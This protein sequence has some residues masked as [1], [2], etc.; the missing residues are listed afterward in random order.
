[1][2]RYVS[3]GS[4]QVNSCVNNAT[5]TCYQIDGHK[6]S[7]SPNECWQNRITIDAPGNYT[8]TVPSGV[9]CMRA[10]A[11]GGGGKSKGQNP[12]CCGM[13]GA[14]GGYSERAFTVTGG[15]IVSVVVG[16]QEANTTITYSPGGV[17]LTGGGANGCTGGS[18][19]G[20]DW[21]STGGCAGF[22]RLYCGGGASHYCGA[23]VYTYFTNCC[24]Y[25]VGWSGVSSRQLDPPHDNAVCCTAMY[26]GGGSAG[27]WI[28]SRGGAGQSAWNNMDNYG[29][30]YGPVA[31][32]GGGIGYIDRCPLR[33]PICACICVGPACNHGGP[34][35]P[36]TSWPA[37]AGG[38]GGSKWQCSQF[39]ICQNY[40]GC[41][42]S[43]RYRSGPGGW[44]GKNNNEGRE[45]WW[46]W[47]FQHGSPWGSTIR[48]QSCY[49]LP[50]PDPKYY[51]W[52]DIHDMQGSGSAG[53]NINVENNDWGYCGWATANPYGAKP[54]RIAGE[55]AG[56]GGI[57]F[58][59]CDLCSFGMQCC[60]T[61]TQGGNA[62]ASLNWLLVCCLGTSGRYDCACRMYDS[63]F[64][65]VINCAG[66]LGG[67]GGIGNCHLG[68][69]AGKGGGSGIFRSYVMCICY[70]GNFDRC[71][72]SGSNPLLAFPP[73]ILDWMASPAGTGMAL[74]YWKDPT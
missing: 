22:N 18:A 16:R 39:C 61:N 1:M 8:F 26:S 6:F 56:T 17:T 28:F 45:D 59:C 24:G 63:I 7:Y 57:V 70:G 51:P 46:T 21:N 23:C 11:I 9:T 48:P 5:R 41:C 3:T 14:G 47:G 60:V 68:G 58:R 13:A 55:G 66:T 15:G 20:G 54:S 27:S 53:R 34:T 35:Q 32:G 71:N 36:R 74:I 49:K 19:S 65:F 10:I 29:Q 50:G 73:C 42:Q 72:N 43:G 40:E 64:P 44:G 2:G 38:G 37:N 69:R 25:C 4:A 62:C 30:G 67:G 52:H 12:N 31:G 33:N